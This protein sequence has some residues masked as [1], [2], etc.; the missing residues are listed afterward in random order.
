M[1]NKGKIFKSALILLA[2]SMLPVL[3]AHAQTTQ[4]K[5]YV[6]QA[7]ARQ[8]SESVGVMGMRVKLTAPVSGVGFTMPTWSVSGKYSAYITA[9]KW[10]GTYSA[11]VAA[12]PFAT[13]QFVALS[14]NA[15]NWLYFEK[16]PAGEY[17]FAIEN[18]EGTVGCWCAADNAGSLGFRYTDG[19]ENK[20][21]MLMTLEVEGNGRN[22]F[23]QCESAEPVYGEAPVY[24]EITE[25]IGRAHV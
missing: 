17:F 5:A 20:G 25:E 7:E 6:A 3:P 21:D 11:T 15:T 22:L 10:L 24:N 4:V 1:K 14:D 12:E 16:Q 9:Y 18:V 13:K 2:L 23:E 19:V 8:I